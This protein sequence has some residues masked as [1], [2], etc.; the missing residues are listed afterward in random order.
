MKRFKRV[1]SVALLLALVTTGGLASKCVAAETSAGQAPTVVTV[2]CIQSSDMMFSEVH[3]QRY[4]NYLVKEYDPQAMPEWEKAFAE[5]KVASD[6]FEQI[7]KSNA[8][9]F[10]TS[11]TISIGTSKVET[12]KQ[13]EINIEKLSDQA[14]GSFTVKL[15]ETSDNKQLDERIQVQKEFEKAVENNDPAAIKSVLPK[16]LADY[17]QATDDMQKTIA[18]SK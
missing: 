13:G 5:R 2:T 17:R 18:N 10:S 12:G 14:N 9:K 3:Q 8:Q 11:G 16:I 6:K 15:A 4:L 1:V 7:V